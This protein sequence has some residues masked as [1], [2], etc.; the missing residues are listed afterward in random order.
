MLYG[1]EMIADREAQHEPAVQRGMGKQ[2]LAR[3][4]HP[5][6]QLAIGL[7]RSLPPEAD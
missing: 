6:E 5:L 7:V 3:R 4:I 1:G 2:R